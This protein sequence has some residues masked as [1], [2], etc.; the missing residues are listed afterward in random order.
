MKILRVTLLAS[1][2]ALCAIIPAAAQ[3]EVAP[4]EE[5]I[6]AAKELIAVTSPDMV[7]DINTKIFSNMWPAMEQGLRIQK[8]ELDATTSD[9]LKNEISAALEKEVIAEVS[10]MLEKMPAVYARYLTVQEMRDIQAFYRTPAGAKALKVMPEIMG[11]TMGQFAP[12]MQGMM[13]RVQVAVLDI[14]KKHG[15]GPQ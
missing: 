2:A 7:R 13:Q 10:G 6:A 5:A 12:R 4:T 11:E 14:L 1:A 15:F 9:A 3:Q 8:P